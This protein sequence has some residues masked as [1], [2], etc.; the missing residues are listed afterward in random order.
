MYC[1]T[2][3]YMWP[4]ILHIYTYIHTYIH[5]YIYVATY[6]HVHCIYNIYNIYSRSIQQPTTVITTKVLLF[7]KSLKN[8]KLIVDGGLNRNSRKRTRT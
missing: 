4:H 6:I 3:M 2:C 8:S 7:F 5:T 1:T